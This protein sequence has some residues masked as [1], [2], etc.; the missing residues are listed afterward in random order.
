MAISLPFDILGL[1]PPA[2]AELL[3]MLRLSTWIYNKQTRLAFDRESFPP[4]GAGRAPGSEF[5]SNSGSAIEG[6]YGFACPPVALADN[7]HRSLI[8]TGDAD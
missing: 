6:E 4:G 5:S 2:L 7:G 8:D 1:P 3:K